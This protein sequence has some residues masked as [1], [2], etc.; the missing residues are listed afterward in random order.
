MTTKYMKLPFKPIRNK[1][2]KNI[3]LNEKNVGYAF[4]FHLN[5]YRG[6]HLSCINHFEV[7]VDGEKID[8]MFCCLNGKKFTPNQFK[9]LYMEWW[10]IK[11]PMRIEV[12]N[13]EGLSEGNHKVE[14]NLYSLC[15]YMKF[16]PGIYAAF[17]SSD[18]ETMTLKGEA[19]LF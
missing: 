11:E 7:K 16:A 5:F 1:E 18:T 15:P 6:I 8:K 13:D 14:I 3:V 17:D 4:E 12:Y 2:I 19:E 10:S 9:D